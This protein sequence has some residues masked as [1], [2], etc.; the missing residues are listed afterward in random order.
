MPVTFELTD[1][2]DTTVEISNWTNAYPVF[3][4]APEYVA[5]QEEAYNETTVAAGIED[6]GHLPNESQM[7]LVASAAK[8]VGMASMLSSS[9]IIYS[10]V[11]TREDRPEKMKTTFH[12]F[13]VTL[14][15]FDIVSSFGFFLS[16]WPIPEEA[17]EGMDEV[18]PV[19]YYALFPW[20]AGNSTTCTLQGSIIQIGSTG[21]GLFTA[22]ISLHYVFSVRYRWT[23]LSLRKFEKVCYFIGIVYPISTAIY[24]A[25]FR[26]YNAM[27]L[28][29]CWINQYP[30]ACDPYN[31][32][33]DSTRELEPWCNSHPDLVSDEAASTS[34]LFFVYSAL[35]M[36]FLIVVVSMI[37]LFLTIRSQE[38]KT[39]RWS[40]AA[41]S[42]RYQKK[43]IQR[44]MLLI[45]NFVVMYVPVIAISAA[46]IL[47]FWTFFIQAVMLASH[48]ILNAL[49]YSRIAEKVLWCCPTCLCGYYDEPAIQERTVSFGV[50]GLSSRVSALSS[51]VGA[52]SSVESNEVGALSSRIIALS[53]V[54]SND[55]LN[56]PA[57]NDPALSGPGVPDYET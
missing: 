45:G 7:K 18:W 44:A 23:E 41:Q 20:A 27:L 54:E 28:S 43:T 36:V 24:L 55:T 56:E 21:S 19:D 25:Y 6:Y 47:N 51:R 30:I 22:F 1:W 9:Y 29:V 37:L 5:E 2:N 39:A 12:R 10:L 4:P 42:G 33:L 35:A 49:V 38:Q 26:Q 34:I 32:E 11:G 3:D 17:P 40:H 14:S 15:A 53:S 57:L 8:V 50:S 16:T 46:K 52:L 31:Y 13:L 48:G